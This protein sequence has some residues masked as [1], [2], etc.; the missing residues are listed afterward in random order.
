VLRGTSG[1]LDNTNAVPIG[2]EDDVS[3]AMGWDFTLLNG[4]TALASL[5]LSEG[6][7]SGFYLG[8]HDPC[9]SHY[10]SSSLVS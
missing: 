7:P 4:Q 5:T 9:G 2:L 10:F 8:Q 3:L 6:I 1:K